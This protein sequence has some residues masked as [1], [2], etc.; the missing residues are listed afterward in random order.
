[1]DSP[2]QGSSQLE[3]I[4]QRQGKIIW[5]FSFDLGCFYTVDFKPQGIQHLTPVTEEHMDDVFYE[6]SPISKVYE[7]VNPYLL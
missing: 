5:Y 6:I 1:M 3:L 2:E 4:V 7:S